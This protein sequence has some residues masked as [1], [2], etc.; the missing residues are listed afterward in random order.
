MEEA[1]ASTEKS[2]RKRGSLLSSSSSSAPRASQ[3]LSVSGKGNR[4]PFNLTVDED[5]EEND[6]EA[7]EESAEATRDEAAMNGNGTFGDDGYTFDDTA[8]LPSN[9]DFLQI[10]GD[11]SLVSNGDG[12]VSGIANNDDLL[13]LKPKRGRHKGNGIRNSLSNG[14][15]S[16]ESDVSEVAMAAP[17]RKGRPPKT[18]AKEPNDSQAPTTGSKRKLS[19]TVEQEVQVDGE[20]EMQG[21]T[22]RPA[23]RAK[24]RSVS[25][26]PSEAQRKG[27]K[28]PPAERD[29][30]A[31]ITSAKGKARASPVEIGSA[32]KKPPRPKPRNLQVLRSETPAEDEGAH[33]TRSGRTSVKP[34]AYWR[35]EQ[36][37]FDSGKID[38]SARVL[39]GIREVIRTKE[40]YE[41]RPKVRRAPGRSRQRSQLEDL[42]EEDEDQEAWELEEGVFHAEVMQWDPVAQRGDEQNIESLGKF[43][44]YVRPNLSPNY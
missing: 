34:I 35:N 10:N 4:R 18:K 38:G 21:E 16:M 43:S 32:F 24:G 20:E 9:E 15:I 37:L 28:P 11:E 17:K 3:L 6:S 2:P 42:E 27:R 29:P 8:P 13:P 5:E 36:L 40:I 41:P 7:L 14:V 44:A 23:K 25:A 33:V 31:R 1:R 39:P 22:P 19:K 30:N 26:T 12:D